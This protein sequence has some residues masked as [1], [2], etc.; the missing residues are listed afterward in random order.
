VQSSYQMFVDQFRHVRAGQERA[1]GDRQHVGSIEALVDGK[2][3]LA[4]RAY[5]MGLHSKGLNA[6]STTRALG[7]KGKGLVDLCGRAPIT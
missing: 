5:P 7:W 4:A 2:F 3:R 1:D 6:A